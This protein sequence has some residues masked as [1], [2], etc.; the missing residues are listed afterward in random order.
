MGFWYLL[1]L[2]MGIILLIFGFSKKGVPADVKIVI[3]FFVIGILFIIISIALLM[4]GSSD[5][6]AQLLK[7]E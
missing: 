3:L 6:I 2:L 1:M 7:L 4:P 5:L